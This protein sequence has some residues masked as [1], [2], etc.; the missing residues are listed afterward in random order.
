MLMHMGQ[1]GNCVYEVD[2]PTR[3][4]KPDEGRLKGRIAELEGVIRELK[5]KPHPRWLAE[6]EGTSSDSSGSPQLSGTTPPL[7]LTQ[8]DLA[9]PRY[10]TPELGPPL[11]AMPYS[12]DPFESLLNMYTGLAEHMSCHRT[13]GGACGCLTEAACYH[14]VLDLSLRLRKAVDVL[15]RSPGHSTNSACALHARIL[16]VDTLVKNMLINVS[17]SRSTFSPGMDSFGVPPNMF[18]HYF[19]Q[20]NPT[21]SWDLGDHSVT[22][23]ESIPWMHARGM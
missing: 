12:N 11:Q 4:G 20:N 5:N 1:T 21:F 6:Q 15:S 14:V 9:S 19:P 17:S 2:D 18:D 22:D 8:W 23:H 7:D 13:R 3:Q 10:Q 16:E